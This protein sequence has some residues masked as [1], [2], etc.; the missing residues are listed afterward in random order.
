MKKILPFYAIFSLW[1][2]WSGFAQSSRSQMELKLGNRIINFS[3]DTA[4]LRNEISNTQGGLVYV[5]LSNGI[6]VDKLKA[7]GILIQDYVG[8][9]TYTIY[10]SPQV[11]FSSIPQLS[12]AQV[13]SE[14]KL[15]PQLSSITQKK[16]GKLSVIIAVKK[17]LTLAELQSLMNGIDA[18]PEK[19]QLWNS[20]DMWTVSV[21]EGDLEKLAASSWVRYINPVLLD[22]AMNTEAIGRTNAG[23][24]RMPFATGGYGLT[25]AGVTVG[26]GDNSDPH[27]IDYEDRIISFNPRVQTN[28]GLHTTGMVGGAGIKDQRYAGFATKSTLISHYFSGIFAYGASLHEDYNMVIT[29]N[30]YG[31]VLGNCWYAGTYDLYSQFLDQQTRT[32]PQLLHVF[33]AGNDGANTCSP[34]PVGFATVAGAYQSAK[35][36]LT[37]GAISKSIRVASA[38][39]SKGPVKDGRLKPEITAVGRRVGSTGFDN[40]YF[41]DTGTSMACPNVAGGATLLYERY[42]QM[43]GVDP[44]A[45]LIKLL[46]MN[47]ATDIFNPGPD[48]VSGFGLM[49]LEH[50]LKMMDS[51]RYFFNTANT[52]DEHTFTFAVPANTSKAKVMLY[53][54]DADALPSAVS[55]LVN[56]LDLSVTRP[57]GTVALPL[58]LNPV[59]SSVTSI[60]TEGEDHTNNVEQV[61]LN[62][63]TPGTY[64][65]KVKGGNVPIAN[66]KYY[67]AY[68]FVPVGVS[69]QYPLGGEALSAGDSTYIYW[70]ASPGTAKFTVSYSVNNGISWNVISSTVADSL[71]ELAWNIPPDISSA[72]CLIK[73]QRNGTTEQ[74]VSSQFVVSPRVI[75]STAP[76]VEQ[77]AGSFKIN[78]TSATGATGYK[79]YLKEDDAMVEKAT[80]PASQLSY[81]FHGMPMTEEQWVSVAPVIGGK[82]GIR[83]VAISRTPNGGGCSGIDIAGDLS[84]EKIIAP[85]SGR[86]YTSTALSNSESIIV[87]IRNNDDEPATNYMISYQLNDNPWISQTFT[88]AIPNAGNI[89]LTLGTP[90]DISAV[91]VYNLKVAIENLSLTDPFTS[92]DTSM[93]VIKHVANEP[94]ELAWEHFEDFEL[95]TNIAKVANEFSLDGAP[96]WDFTQSESYGRI[97]GFVMSDVTISGNGSISMDNARNQRN[98]IEGS[99][100]NTLTGTFNLGELDLSGIETRFEFEYIL[101]SKPKFYNQNKVMIRGSESDPWITVLQFDTLG[102]GTVKRSPSISLNDYFLANGQNFSS[103]SQIRIAQRD[104]SLIGAADFGNGLTID[105]FRIYQVSN[106]V[107][108]LSVESIYRQSCAASAT[109]PVQVKV[110]NA[111]FYPIYNITLFYQLDDGPIV[112]G[113][114]DSIGGKDTVTYTF[115]STIDLSEIGEHRLSVWIHCPDDSYNEND[116]IMNV[117]IVNQPIISSFPYLENFEESNGFYYTKGEN[118]SWEYGIPNS[119]SVKYAASGTKAWK[120]GLNGYYNPMEISYLYSPCFDISHLVRPALSFSLLHEIEPSDEF[121]IYD[122]AW[123]EY[124]SDG[125]TWTKL[126]T[127]STGYNWYN[128]TTDVWIGDQQNYWSVA[129]VPIPKESDIFMFRFAF[130]SDSGAEYEGIAIDNIH[131]Y[132]RKFLLLHEENTATVMEES[133][134]NNVEA[135]FLKEE[136]IMAA[137][138]NLGATIEKV[139]VTAYAHET[140]SSFDG[141]QYILPYNFSIRSRINPER[142]TLKLFVPDTA[143]KR[144]REDTLCTSCPPTKEVY[145]MGIT[146]YSNID[147]ELENGSLMDNK[148]GIYSFKPFDQV[149]WVPYDIGYYAEVEVNSFSEIWFNDG[150]PTGNMGLKQLP[151]VF[152]AVAVDARSVLVSWTSYIDTSVVLYEIESAGADMAFTK[153]AE[154]SS[155]GLVAAKYEHIDKP[156]LSG[157]ITYY[158]LRYQM[159]DGRWI[160]S[161]IEVVNWDA[162]GGD[163]IVYPNPARDGIITL[164]WFKGNNAPID[165]IVSDIHGRAIT[166]GRIEENVFAGN[167]TINIGALGLSTGIYVLKV[168]SGKEEWN[169]KVVLQE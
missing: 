138:K 13:N 10:M 15:A 19:S 126:G 70:E 136:K 60:A 20:Q 165:W 24:A 43:H 159:N 111:V 124:S 77:C 94:L 71:R 48:Y 8:D 6:D 91:G 30:S 135:V 164:D 96:Q 86:Q 99:S 31:A 157:S 166:Q 154:F 54:A 97:R 127:H 11:N 106:D 37:V 59:S 38:Y 80:V 69:L 129:T 158:R 155:K 28:H 9:N 118:S 47:G 51:S 58:I 67:V 66:Q 82:T 49:N 34:Y 108:L 130:Y 84:V 2:C 25:G 36:V 113:F 89:T 5:K 109:S 148:G 76:E 120:T 162:V 62:S 131:I 168:V 105:N 121:S 119:P 53:W 153:I 44:D 72:Q 146:Q 92:N 144:V 115:S 83:A 101:H 68:D 139:F 95:S 102:T 29:N 75:V 4:R 65:I 26:V 112:T 14:D 156:N 90:L 117:E 145:R 22:E 103:S 61:V 46:L 81:Q 110:R 140:I 134:P 3:A 45:A 160:Y 151:L 42:K 56:D 27:H 39:S 79:V 147:R 73:V 85:V 167:H 116:S 163:M 169:F 52:G 88:L 98:N 150:G 137:V 32:Y 1:T 35:N 21:A 107:E 152:T 123:V 23:I 63:P 64:T 16:D 17:G 122:R 7:S 161:T 128:D 133:I 114:I 87:R 142:V 18:E 125:N 149:T 50:S 12:W 74:S 40:D 33:A 141:M 57:G 132:E 100:L 41:F 78:W 143:I 55:T 93:I 104:T